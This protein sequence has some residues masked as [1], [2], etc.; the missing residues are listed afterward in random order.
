MRTA[1]VGDKSNVTIL[2]RPSEYG[3]PEHGLLSQG[4]R[5]VT[6][7]QAIASQQLLGDHRHGIRLT[8]RRLDA[9]VKLIESA[10]NQ[11]KK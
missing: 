3:L 4:A 6:D 5:R 8:H 9:V 7:R 2:T 11:T 1:A 10:P